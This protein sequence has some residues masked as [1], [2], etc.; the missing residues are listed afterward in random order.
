MPLLKLTGITIAFGGPPVLEDVDL[1]VEA[2][3]RLC[4]LG[5]NCTPIEGLDCADFGK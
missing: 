5:R 1:V 4:L 3:E 2:G